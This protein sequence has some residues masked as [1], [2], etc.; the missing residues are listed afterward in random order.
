[1]RHSSKP[2][3]R[4]RFPVPPRAGVGACQ[5]PTVDELVPLFGET[6]H[7]DPH[8]GEGGHESLCDFGDGVP[9]NRRSVS[10][11]AKRSLRR[12]EGSHAGGLLAVPRCG[13]ALGEIAQLSCYWH[14]QMGRAA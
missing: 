6:V 13:V 9:T 1:M 11:D 3:M 2:L 4:T 12:V 8:V 10:V 5:R 14:S 7:E